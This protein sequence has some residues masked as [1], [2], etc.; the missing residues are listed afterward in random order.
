MGY[1][2]DQCL[3]C[4]SPTSSALLTLVMIH[5]HQNG[6]ITSRA[7]TFLLQQI[8]RLL[9]KALTPE[10][11]AQIL[12]VVEF[13][14]EGIAALQECHKT[15]E[16]VARDLRVDKVVGEEFVDGFDHQ[17]LEDALSNYLVEEFAASGCHD[18]WLLLKGGLRAIVF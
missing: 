8:R 5:S 14:S 6:N 13:F 9:H 12:I 3:F 2:R 16:L 4:L 10:T 18:D 17:E 11:H 1:S 15:E 7:T